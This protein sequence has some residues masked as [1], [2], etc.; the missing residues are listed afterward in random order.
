MSA[1]PAAAAL[2]AGVAASSTGYTVIVAILP[3]AAEDLLGSVRWSG[4]PSSLATTGVA[5][6]SAVL[7]GLTIRRGRR[8]ALVTGYAAAA[9]AAGVAALAAAAG[10]F[11]PLLA[12]NFVLG[13]GYAANRLSRYAAADLYP[14]LHRSAAIGWNVWAATVGSV[15][16]PLLLGATGRASA[17]LSIPVVSGPFLLAGASLIVAALALQLFYRPGRVGR[18]AGD[19]SSPD[20]RVES[21]AGLRLGVASLVVAQVVMVL[22][23]TMTPIHIRHEGHGL[24]VVGV[25][26]ASHTF[27]MFAL[28]PLAGILS[29]RIGRVPVVV[30]ACV[31]LSASG[32]LAA[33]S[34]SGSTAHAVAL[35]LLGLGWCLSFVAASALVTESVSVVRR[36]R[37]QGRVDSLVWGSA[38]VAGLASGLLL[39]VVG[40]GTLSRVG[41][42]LAL[43]PL[44]VLSPLGRRA[45]S[46]ERPPW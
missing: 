38:A 45:D 23:M 40:Y 15:V 19:S 21:P 25:V 43:V 39:S 4:L 24:D 6:G 46:R 17:A 44:F 28:S 22:I 14:P 33:E 18:V 9:L 30:A 12:A 37:L 2:F 5:V 26:F 35:L 32:I 11:L 13:G 10:A 34:A 36:V 3:L 8:V 31:V 29:D 1:R 27:G 41:A 20:E 42:V 7:A 16:G